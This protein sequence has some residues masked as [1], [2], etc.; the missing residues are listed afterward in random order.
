M[1][2]YLDL[3]LVITPLR[4]PLPVEEWSIVMSVS[5]CLSVG[6]FQEQHVQASSNCPR[7]LPVDMA[8]VLLARSFSGDTVVFL[9]CG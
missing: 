7:L 8:R 6:I 4:S 2:D 1:T 9:F 5:V 3:I